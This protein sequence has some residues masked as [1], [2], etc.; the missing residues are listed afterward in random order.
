MTH[1]W[2]QPIRPLEVNPNNTDL[3]IPVMFIAVDEHDVGWIV[4]SMGGHR[5]RPHNSMLRTAD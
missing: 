4:I 3:W 1:P 2:Q 5:Y